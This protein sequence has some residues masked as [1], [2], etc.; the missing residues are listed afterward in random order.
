MAGRA[1]GGG[2]RYSWDRTGPARLLDAATTEELADALDD[3]TLLEGEQACT[4]DLGP[5]WMI[6]YDHGGDLTGVVVDDYGCRDVRLTD[7]PF[8]TPPG[9]PGQEGTVEGI[10]GGGADLL[11]G[12]GLGG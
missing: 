10:L 5:R 4:A 2:A 1:P 11:E 8:A 9:A 12:L 7:E 3:L 6:V